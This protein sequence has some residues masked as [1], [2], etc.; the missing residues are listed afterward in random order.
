MDRQTLLPNTGTVCLIAPALSAASAC[1]ICIFLPLTVF[2]YGTKFTGN[3][4]TCYVCFC[5]QPEPGIPNADTAGEMFVTPQTR[6]CGAHRESVAFLRTAKLTSRVC[7]RIRCISAPREQTFVTGCSLP[8]AALEDQLI[9]VRLRPH[10]DLPTFSRA[11]KIGPLKG[12][13]LLAATISEI[14]PSHLANSV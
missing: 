12:T 11:D 7:E 6:P 3:A 4:G 1:G 9:N 13:S 8:D 14:F 2:L 10:V 5:A